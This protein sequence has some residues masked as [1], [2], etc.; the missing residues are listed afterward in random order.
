MVV[1]GALEAPSPALQAGATPSQLTDQTL[2]DMPGYDPGTLVCR[3]SAFP[4]YATRPKWREGGESNSLETGFTDQRLTVWL[5]TQ[6]GAPGRTQT[7][8]PSLTRRDIISNASGANLNQSNTIVLVCQSKSLGR[9]DITPTEPL[10]ILAPTKLNG[11]NGNV[12]AEISLA[13]MT[14]R[15]T[16]R[17]CPK[18]L[19]LKWSLEL[20]S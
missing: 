12:R 20:Q 17:R 6:Y 16:T 18:S 8:F 13:Q 15:D 9:L 1:C 3:T 14:L 2:V 4:N 19:E 5:P 7:V 11:L 10:C